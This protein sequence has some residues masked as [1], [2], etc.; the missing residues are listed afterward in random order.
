[1]KKNKVKGFTLIE[2]L[3]VI[4]ILAIIALIVTPVVSNI[5]ANARIAANARSVEGHI[6]NIELAIITQAFGSTSTGDLDSYDTITSGASIESSLSRAGNDNVT[7]TSYTIKHG[8]VLSA[9]GC[10]DT[11][12]KWGKKYKYTNTDGAYVFEFNGT[13]IWPGLDGDE[14]TYNVLIANDGT[15][16]NL[17]MA[18][19]EGNSIVTYKGIV[20]M[21]PT[22]PKTVCNT[23]NTNTKTNK[24]PNCK[25]FYIYD[26]SGST[27]KMI[28]DRNTTVAVTW[29][30]KDTKLAT[31]TAGWNATGNARLIT[32][33]E[34][35]HIVGADREDTIKWNSSKEYVL[36]G[37]SVTDMDTQISRFYLDGLYSSNIT[38]YNDGWS[39]AYVSSTVKS[40]YAWLYDYTNECV[41]NYGCYVTSGTTSKGYWTSNKAEGV[42]ENAWLVYKT[43]SIENYSYTTTKIGIRP[44]LEVPKSLLG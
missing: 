21:D 24:D 29:T 34:V 1:M 3:A 30:N 42:D 16:I 38:K 15:V 14:T 23:T 44:V 8:T 25:K 2:L 6:R 31:D 26:D 43:A 18:D 19:S 39:K 32:V 17:P 40:N 35:A 36:Y 5:V 22:N 13:V 7:C 9:G 33:D 11:E 12:N 10:K 27:Y 41:Y 28:M 20:Y 4:V 37:T